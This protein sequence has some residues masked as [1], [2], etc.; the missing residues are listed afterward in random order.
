MCVFINTL[1]SVRF[2]ILTVI[3]ISFD[4]IYEYENNSESAGY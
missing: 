1:V 3:S 2:Q 4:F